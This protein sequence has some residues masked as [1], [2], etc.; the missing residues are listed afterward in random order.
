ML[1]GMTDEDWDLVLRGVPRL[2]V[3]ARRQGSRRPQVPRGLALFLCSTTSPGG[4][5]LRSLATWNSVWK[6]FWRLEP[7]RGLRGL[8]PGARRHQPHRPSRADLRL[9]HRARACLGGG[10][11]RGQ[12]SQALGR[13]RGGFST[14]IHLK[15]DLR[16]PAARLPPDRRPG[17]R[18]P[19]VRDPPRPR[20]RH[21]AARRHRRQGLRE[22]QANR[23]AARAQRHL[24][25]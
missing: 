21:R 18:Q 1:T 15:T 6:R 24:P 13:S 7:G 19:A 4:P 8:L 17:Q 23:A 11:Q 10:S 25:R 5:C 22:S 2:A 16:R 20:S 14:K 3:P 12:Q 9:H